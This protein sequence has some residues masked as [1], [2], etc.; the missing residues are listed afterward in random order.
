MHALGP[1]AAGVPAV[2]KSGVFMHGVR[3]WPHKCG[4][5]VLR[6]CFKPGRGGAEWAKVIAC[7]GKKERAGGGLE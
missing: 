6:L 4:T 5:G 3:R 2:S 7:R 1:C